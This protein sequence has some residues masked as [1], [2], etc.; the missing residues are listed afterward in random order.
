MAQPRE[1][2]QG[3]YLEVNLSWGQKQR[4]IQRLVKACDL[5]A[6]VERSDGS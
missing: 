3:Y 5:E 6:T 2:K 1:L 4:E